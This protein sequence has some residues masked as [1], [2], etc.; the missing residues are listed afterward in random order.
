MIYRKRSNQTNHTLKQ[1]SEWTAEEFWTRKFIM[2]ES[3]KE[4]YEKDLI[5]LRKNLLSVLTGL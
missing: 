5:T 1:S 2:Q 4:H 3:S